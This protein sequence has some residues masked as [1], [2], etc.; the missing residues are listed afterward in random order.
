[1]TEQKRDDFGGG[2]VQ[3]EAQKTASGEPRPLGKTSTGLD[4]RLAAFLSYLLSAFIGFFSGL[5]FY[6][7]ERE[8]KY[9]RFHALQSIFFTLAVLVISFALTV[10]SVIAPFVP[11]LGLVIV[12]AAWLVFLVGIFGLWI[13]L[14]D[15]A[16]KGIYYI[17]PVIGDWA[18]R[19]A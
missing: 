7:T 8:N 11:V 14:M 16:Y 18:D 5:I 2:A 3:E 17:L 4:P 9:V 15:K 10:F 13:V 12:G 6:L 19:Y 1:M